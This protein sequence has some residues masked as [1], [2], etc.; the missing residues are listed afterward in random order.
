MISV[1][2]WLVSVDRASTSMRSFHKETWKKT[3]KSLMSINQECHKARQGYEQVY[4]QQGCRPLP[5]QF[6]TQH[7]FLMP[8]CKIKKKTVVK[9]HCTCCSINQGFSTDLALGP[10]FS[11]GR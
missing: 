9:G 11:H 1:I 3:S 6:D 10:T 8:S 4:S 2:A 5:T 7:M